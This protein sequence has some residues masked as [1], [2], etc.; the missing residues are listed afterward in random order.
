MAAA[1]IPVGNLSSLRERAQLFLPIFE[2]NL[3]RGRSFRPPEKIE[4]VSVAAALIECRHRAEKA[5]R[6]FE[7]DRRIASNA[8]LECVPPHAPS[9]PDLWAR[10]IPQEKQL[11]FSDLEVPIESKRQ[12]LDSGQLAIFVRSVHEGDR[13]QKDRP[14]RRAESHRG[15]QSLPQEAVKLP[16]AA[17]P[18]APPLILHFNSHLHENSGRREAHAQTRFRSLPSARN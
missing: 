16:L 4:I 8:A 11:R 7:I 3:D 1:R 2:P 15:I 13:E 18:S 17:S 12:L 6:T 10:R 14:K 9:A 5:V